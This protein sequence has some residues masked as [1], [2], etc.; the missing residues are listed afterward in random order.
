MSAIGIVVDYADRRISNAV[1]EYRYVMFAK[2]KKFANPFSLLICTVP[3]PPGVGPRLR[4][5]M[6]KIL[7]DIYLVGG[8]S[9]CV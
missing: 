2:T 9:L 1:I 4:N 8:L 5:Y 6:V 3:V 7:F